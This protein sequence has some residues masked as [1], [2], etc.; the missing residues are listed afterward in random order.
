MEPSSTRRATL[1]LDLAAETVAG[2][3]RDGA[4]VY[5]F[6]G[7]LELATAIEAWRAAVLALQSAAEPPA[8]AG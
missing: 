3:L 7:W 8:E 2:E 5:R 6:S 4:A 1:E